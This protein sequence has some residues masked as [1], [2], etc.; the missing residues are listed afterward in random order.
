MEDSD[1]RFGGIRRL[2]GSEGAERLRRAHVCIVGLGGV[3]SWAVEG[4][5][6]SAIGALTL[7][8]M[9]EVCI[10]NVNRQIHAINGVIGRPKAEVMADRVRA[11]HPGCQVRAIPE[12]FGPA[13]AGELLQAGYDFVFDA[14][15]NLANKCLLIA[16]CRQSQIPVIASGGAGG[17]RDPSAIRLDD[18]AFTT[19]DRLLAAVRRTLRKEHAF[20][21][22]PRERFDVPCV[23]SP[24]PMVYP[25]SDG[26]ICPQPE[27]GLD[28]RRDCESGYG[29]ASFVTGSFGFLAAGYMAEAIVG[30]KTKPC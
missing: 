29:T 21:Q 16:L 4:L 26:S 7:I 22:N 9:D 6:R 14:I 3:G 30:E 17:R 25:H 11:I 19:N 12:F 1:M 5:A 20:P 2:Y 8:D 23:Y 24:E 18:L 28:L 27:P 13:N 15:D 10:S